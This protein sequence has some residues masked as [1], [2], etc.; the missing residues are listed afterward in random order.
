M[1]IAGSILVATALL[2]VAG[3]ALAET[4]AAKPTE[5]FLERAV[6]SSM[7]EVALGK[8]AQEHAQST[9]VNALGAR[10]AHDHAKLGKVLASVSRDRGVVVPVSLDN[11]QRARVDLLSAK[12]GADFDAAYTMQM[13]S[14]HENAVALFTAVAESGDSDLSQIAKFALPMLREDQRL[15]NSYQKLNSTAD[16]Q[17]V[18]HR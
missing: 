2:W 12:T 9:G 3:A 6:Q 5:Q 14:D 4:P 11:T 7:L 10:L 17:A 13:V 8:L 1:R 18:A 15:A 16:L